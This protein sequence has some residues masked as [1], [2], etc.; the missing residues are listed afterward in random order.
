MTKRR[1][2]LDPDTA[3]FFRKINEM[4][5]PKP[6]APQ[7]SPADETPEERVRAFNAL[8]VLSAIYSAIGWVAV[9][10]GLVM[11]LAGLWQVLAVANIGGMF[12]L[13]LRSWLIGAALVMLFA[14]ITFLAVSE[15]IHLLMAIRAHTHEIAEATELTS[16]ALIRMAAALE[17]SGNNPAPK[18]ALAEIQFNSKRAAHA[19]EE[20]L[21]IA[22][23]ATARPKSQS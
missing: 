21:N 13:L 16:A 6:I 12:A 7:P 23:R 3:Y 19:S 9:A 22:Q 10:V 14:G 18:D 1:P 2:P 5:K 17:A 8:I 20:L 4:G 15:L 11:L